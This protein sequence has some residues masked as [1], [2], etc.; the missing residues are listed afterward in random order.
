MCEKSTEQNR[1]IEILKIQFE[2]ALEHFK[3]HAQQRTTVFNFFLIMFGVSTGGIATL[4][5]K[6]MLYAAAGVSISA[7]IIALAFLFLD[8]RNKHLIGYG[9][10]VLK[11]LEE[12][13]IFKGKKYNNVTLGFMLRE[14]REKHSRIERCQRF[15]R[16]S[17]W[18]PTIQGL[19]L[20]A[21]LATAGVTLFAP[22]WVSVGCS[23]PQ[24]E[25]K[26][27]QNELPRE[28]KA[29]SES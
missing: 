7:A 9:E 22:G 25:K 8:I 6:N 5:E 19:A 15:F 14:D 11:H 28:E 18:I 1:E 13:E 26:P 3:H 16:H 4:I 17:L 24:A 21:F 10:H 29:G 12:H 27:E 23:I 20:A 2:Y